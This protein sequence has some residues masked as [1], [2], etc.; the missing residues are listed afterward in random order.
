MTLLIWVGFIGLMIFINWLLIEKR[1]NPFHLLNALIACIFAAMFCYHDIRP[2]WFN[3]PCALFTY[4]FLFD[5]GLN[6]ARGEY[7]WYLGKESVIDKLSQKLPLQ[8]VFI[9]KGILA[10]GFIACYYLNF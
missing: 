1:I 4:W 6:L 2:L 3:I 5:T 9:F 10:L 8:V 7:I